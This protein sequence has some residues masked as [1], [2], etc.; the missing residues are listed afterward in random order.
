MKF[1]A[2]VLG[3]LFAGTAVPATAQPSPAKAQISF[4]VE[5]PQVEPAAY[6]LEIYED[7]SGSYRASYTASA[8]GNSAPEP[9]E[10]AVQI[11]DP[12]LAKMFLDARAHR[13]FGFDC[14]A[15]HSHVAFTGKKTLAYTGPD[16][17]GSCT[18]NYSKEQWLDQLARSL[19]SVAYTLEEGVRLKREQRYD[20]LSLDNE[21]TSLQEAVQNGQA[22]EIENIRPELQS[23]VR[24]AA[25]MNRA[26]GRAYRL[27][28][29][30]T[31]ADSHPGK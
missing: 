27:M 30:T 6:S 3:L 1:T 10:R 17:A 5:Q 29:E 8:T 22:L 7:G 28:A 21:L 26:R 24:D 2:V 25:V 13:Y 9:V 15:R 4:T 12:L 18:F 20:K 19:Q 23:I 16:G 11:H 14:E 31:V